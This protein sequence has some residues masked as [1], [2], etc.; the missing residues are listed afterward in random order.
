MESVS[1]IYHPLPPPKPT[2]NDASHFKTV[3]S[4]W[5]SPFSPGLEDELNKSQSQV[6]KFVSEK[7]VLKEQVLGGLVGWQ[8]LEEMVGILE[9]KLSFFLTQNTCFLKANWRRSPLDGWHL[10][11]E[12]N[13]IFVWPKSK[14]AGL[15]DKPSPQRFA[16][17]L[18][19]PLSEHTHL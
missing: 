19:G 18:V 8:C 6:S 16:T 4:W 7:L 14:G 5:F 9:E 10:F 2:T 11:R 17:A 3:F 15:K 12:I 13:R 1:D